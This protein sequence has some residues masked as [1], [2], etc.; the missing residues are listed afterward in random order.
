MNQVSWKR[1]L[2]WAVALFVLGTF[3]Y[4]LEYKYNPLQEEKT[5]QSKKIFQIKDRVIRSIELKHGSLKTSIRCLDVADNLCKP[6]NSSKWELVAPNSLK[7]DNANVTSLLSSFQSLSAQDIISLKE[8]PPEKRASLLKE[9]G[10]DLASRNLSTSRKVQ[11][12]TDEGEISLYFGQEHPLGDSSFALVSR[13]GKEPDKK[14]EVDELH[15]YLV[16]S[17][18]KSHFEHDLT[19]WRDK[20]LLTVNAHEI[21]SFSLKQGQSAKQL[22]ISGARKEGKWTLKQ[23]PQLE[24]A[25]DV[26]ADSEKITSFLNQIV[27]LSAKA[28]PMNGDLDGAALIGKVI[29]EKEKENNPIEISFLEKK[30][31]KKG[32]RLY[33]TVSNLKTPFELDLSVRGSLEKT[34]KDF[35]LTKLITPME[36]FSIKRIEFTGKPIGKDPLVLTEVDLSSEKVRNF[37]DK[38]SSNNIDQ[39][40]MKTEVPTG[41]GEGIKLSVNADQPAMKREW[42][43]WKKENRL[44]ARDLVAQ[45]NNV[46]LLSTTMLNALPWDPNFFK[47]K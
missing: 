35:R 18:F 34:L 30:L 24:V 47:S 13:S 44:Y 25:E 37:L 19:Y 5:E 1:Q 29:L 6:G 11:L 28:F 27:G 40:L 36:R 9:Y 20:K 23:T 46:F 15:V 10:L 4:W 33:A 14:E 42:I 7:A 41:E 45:R 12:L 16:P 39:F 38:L 26:I 31:G 22:F 43:F 2:L 32:D 17:Y 21:V 3:A 8:D